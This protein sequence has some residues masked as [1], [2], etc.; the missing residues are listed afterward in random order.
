M[1]PPATIIPSPSPSLLLALA[2]A[3]ALA[4]APLG[5][6]QPSDDGAE[7]IEL[8]GGLKVKDLI[9]GDGE[10]ARRGQMLQVRYTGWLEDGT[11]FDSNV[12]GGAPLAF[13]LGAGRVIK[14]WERGLE[15]MRVGG[16][17]QLW[18]PSKL[19]YGRRGAGSKIPPDADLTFEVELVAVSPAPR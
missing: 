14:G 12:E 9:V 16:R 6:Q 1:K 10:E 11:E 4:V 2:F 15:G 19:G 17:R 8:K 5:G 13:E 3:F 7:W 18:I